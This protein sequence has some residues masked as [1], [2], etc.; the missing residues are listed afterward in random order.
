V[1]R[2]ANVLLLFLNGRTTQN[3]AWENRENESVDGQYAIIQHMEIAMNSYLNLWNCF[4]FF[5]KDA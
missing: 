1:S 3:L 2:N 5:P 4:Y